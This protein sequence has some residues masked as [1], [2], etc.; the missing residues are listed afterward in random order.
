M[1][2]PGCPSERPSVS[3]SSPRHWSRRGRRS[4]RERRPARNADAHGRPVVG[5]EEPSV[6]CRYR[7]QSRPCES[8]SRRRKADVLPLLRRCGRR[9][10]TLDST[11]VA[12]VL[13]VS[14]KVA[15]VAS[16]EVRRCMKSARQHP[17]ESGPHH[18]AVRGGAP[19]L[20][21][22]PGATT[23]DRR[24][25]ARLQLLQPGAHDAAWHRRWLELQP[26]PRDARGICVDVRDPAT[27][28]GVTGADRGQVAYLKLQSHRDCSGGPQSS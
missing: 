20:R 17:R 27:S 12:S 28:G 4:K 9:S 3:R 24:A 10:P 25:A 21:A 7:T 16:L 2:R 1:A 13:A 19:L 18:R 26:V 14:A 15:T 5:R 6:R 23:A 22:A 11:N 8:P